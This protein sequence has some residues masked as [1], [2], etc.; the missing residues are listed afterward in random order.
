MKTILL[1]IAA[2]TACALGAAQKEEKMPKGIPES[3]VPMGLGVNIHFIEPPPHD[4]DMIAAAGFRFIRMDFSWVHIERKQGEYDFS[5]YAQLVDALAQRGIRPLFILDYGNPLYDNDL[6]PHTD[7]GRE[8]FARFAAAGA[9]RFK[10]RGVLWELWNEPNIFFWRPRPNVDDYMALAKV[11][12]PAVR[13]ADP[14]ATLVA[15]ATSGV[16]LNFL[17]RCFEQG[18]LELIDAVSVHPYRREPPETVTRDYQRLRALI[19]RYAP[20]GK[21]VP[22]LS[23]E[24]GYSVTWIPKEQQGQY[25]ARQFLINLMNDVPLSIW[26]DWRDDGQDPNDQEHNFGTITWD[27]QPKPAYIAAQTLI[28]ELSGFRFTKRLSLSSANDYALIFSRGKEQKLALWTTGEPHRV[29]LHLG[30]PSASVVSMIGEK[31]T[32]TATNGTLSLEIS[33]SPQYLTPS[34]PSQLLQLESAWRVESQPTFKAG[35][36]A[37]HA[38]APRLKVVM[39]NPLNVPLSGSVEAHIPKELSGKWTR[40]NRFRLKP[41]ETAQLTW[42]GTFAL[43]EERTFHVPVTVRVEGLAPMT[44]EVTWEVANPLR[45]QLALR[46][47]AVLLNVE[48]PAGE[49]FEG[50][51][52]LNAFPVPV[53]LTAGERRK[54][55]SVPLSPSAKRTSTFSLTLA[56]KGNPVMTPLPVRFEALE[57]FDQPQSGAAYQAVLDG[58]AKVPAK[59]DMRVVDAP[60]PNAPFAKACRVDYEFGQGWR[61][62]RVTPKKTLPIPGKPKAVGMW[63]YNTH[64]TRDWLRCRIVDAT[65]QTFQPTASEPLTWQGW[66]WVTMRLDDPQVGHWGGANDGV[67]HYPIRWDSIFLIDSTSHPHQGTVY[68]TGVTLI[69][70]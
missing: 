8:A 16:D 35:V 33:G 61:F 40:G 65:G 31:R 22:I 59:L 51:A 57:W 64:N 1:L 49:P 48:N 63:V 30:V 13:R 55:F 60:D 17:E 18:L 9:A 27:Y 25:L 56:A 10:G 62:L 6:A 39:T 4:V 24:W 47:D 46:S 38:S 69:D 2:L 29:D 58:D 19:A 11:A 34:Q 42:Q 41:N 26:Y 3:V 36:P 68:F 70:F 32:L 67:I 14:D 50:T 44:Q 43:R 37:A 52:T 12:L 53:R 23:G 28:Q 7:A 21:S 54:T 45:M 5:G 15:P 20:K 66:R